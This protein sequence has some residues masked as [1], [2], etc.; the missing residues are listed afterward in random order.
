MFHA[1][2]ASLL[3]NYPPAKKK[4]QTKR[5][6]TLNATENNHF[7]ICYTTQNRIFFPMKQCHI[8]KIAYICT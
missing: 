1:L 3:C 8:R 4:A 6:M 2:L 5:R 7:Q